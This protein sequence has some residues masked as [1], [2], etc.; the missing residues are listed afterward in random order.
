MRLKSRKLKRRRSKV[1]K[2]CGQL[3][4]KCIKRQLDDFEKQYKSETVCLKKLKPVVLSNRRSVAE[5]YKIAVRKSCTGKG[6]VQVPKK[7]VEYA[8]QKPGFRLINETCRTSITL[9]YYYKKRNL[10][11]KANEVCSSKIRIRHTKCGQ[12]KGGDIKHSTNKGDG[13]STIVLTSTVH[14]SITQNDTWN[15][16]DDKNG[17]KGFDDSDDEASISAEIFL[18]LLIIIAVSI[19][20]LLILMTCIYAYVYKRSRTRALKGG[21][22]KGRRTGRKHL[23]EG[24]NLSDLTLSFSARK[25]LS[26]TS[27]ETSLLCK[28]HLDKLPYTTLDTCSHITT[29][30][31][32][33]FERTSS[34]TEYYKDI[35]DVQARACGIGSLNHNIVKEEIIEI[36][37]CR[38]KLH[39]ND[40]D[41]SDTP[42]RSIHSCN[43]L[44]SLSDPLLPE[45]I[46]PVKPDGIFSEYDC[47][48]TRVDSFDSLYSGGDCGDWLNEILDITVS[49][50]QDTQINE[51]K[52]LTEEPI[53]VSIDSSLSNKDNTAVQPFDTDRERSA[54][55]WNKHRSLPIIPNA[56]ILYSE[57][58]WLDGRLNRFALSVTSL[59]KTDRQYSH[60]YFENRLRSHEPNTQNRLSKS[61]NF[62]C[63]KPVTLC[64]TGKANSSLD[65][66]CTTLTDVRLL[67]RSTGIW[68]DFFELFHLRVNSSV[69]S[70]SSLHSDE[71]YAKTINIQERTGQHTPASLENMSLPSESSNQFASFY[72]TTSTNA[73]GSSITHICLGDTS[74]LFTNERGEDGQQ[75]HGSQEEAE[76]DRKRIENVQDENVQDEEDKVGGERNNGQQEQGQGSQEEAENDKKRVENVQDEEDM[77]DGKRNN[78]QQ[79]QRQDSQQ[80]TDDIDDDIDDRLDDDIDDDLNDDIVEEEREEKHNHNEGKEDLEGEIR[81]YNNN[82]SRRSNQQNTITT[83]HNNLRESVDTASG[84]P[85]SLDK[86]SNQHDQNDFRFYYQDGGTQTKTQNLPRTIFNTDWSAEASFGVSGGE[87]QTENSSVKLIVVPGTVKESESITINAHVHVNLKKLVEVLAIPKDEFIVS[88]APEY[89]LN[90]DWKK[91]IKKPMIILLPVTLS[92]TFITESLTVYV[93]QS[94]AGQIV[95]YPIG[96]KSKQNDNGD[97]PYFE[98]SKDR[99]NILIYTYHFS[100]V[101]ACYKCSKDVTVPG[102]LSACIKGSNKPQKHGREVRI[103]YEIF[104]NKNEIKDFEVQNQHENGLVLLEKRVRINLPANADNDSKLILKLDVVGDESNLW[105]SKKLPSGEEMFPMELEVYLRELLTCSSH[106]D[107]FDT[108]WVM[109][110]LP[111]SPEEL[112]QPFECRI[113]VS[114]KEV[115]GTEGAVAI[116]SK[117]KSYVRIEATT[118]SYKEEMSS[119]NKSR[120]GSNQVLEESRANHCTQPISERRNLHSDNRSMAELDNR[121]FVRCVQEVGL[122]LSRQD[123]HQQDVRDDSNGP[124]AMAEL[125]GTDRRSPCENSDNTEYPSYCDTQQTVPKVYG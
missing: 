22:R 32:H 97:D 46:T 116:S 15:P 1:R 119:D 72:S 112:L 42:I 125:T 105:E 7:C 38:T 19:T 96:E 111:E 122:P 10:K 12:F 24:T 69:I 101:V 68:A 27:L 63:P 58:N 113:S 29:P 44:C 37:T 35:K 78:G 40:V 31:L 5:Y 106:L 77:V 107:I 33:S 39:D 11:I 20:T 6:V 23:E 95:K 94:K 93:F 98:V 86:E 83:I 109:R 13:N 114:E 45:D 62:I 57:L 73:S 80:E 87:L 34:H 110:G 66:L 64:S 74:H 60:D 36:E 92:P 51:F 61:L 91:V 28:P 59:S 76:N 82:K 67:R 85:L 84:K 16:L 26:E 2:S 103:R 50:Q 120:S 102:Y 48:C 4:D 25:I 9:S 18:L 121:E 71:D 99:K 117:N 88:P 8:K 75:G 124:Q 115:N 53:D 52:I 118:G 21:K 43:E 17:T 55:F 104:D 41:T 89:H 90:A 79:E 123:L 56:T 3:R 70:I 100:G 30:C 49:D 47:E 54:M 65:V 14:K 108:E 81:S